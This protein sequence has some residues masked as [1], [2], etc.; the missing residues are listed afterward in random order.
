MGQIIK[1]NKLNHQTNPSNGKGKYMK[2]ITKINCTRCSE[3][4]DYLTINNITFEIEN[5]EDKGYIY[6][7]EL[8]K[9]NT[10]KA[11]F[12]IIIKN[13]IIENGTKEELINFI[14][15]NN[16]FTWGI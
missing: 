1:Q 3:I 5:A 2:L 4:K 8:V 7:R 13:N 12:P 11:G 10:G 9:E 6:W 16:T 15:N 14:N